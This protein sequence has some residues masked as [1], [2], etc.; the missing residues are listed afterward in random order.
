MKNLTKGFLFAVL[1]T[2]AAISSLNAQTL[3]LQTT[4]EY[5][6]S[7]TALNN[8]VALTQT[9]QNVTAVQSMTY[10]FVARQTP[11]N[12]TEV[13]AYFT[14]WDPVT[15]R[16]TSVTPLWTP[17]GTQTIPASTNPSWQ[18]FTDRNG[19]DYL[20]Y[21]YT[22]TPAMAALNPNQTYAIILRAVSNSGLTATTRIG[23][24]Q[25]F[26]TN[27]SDVFTFGSAL[28]L[29]STVDFNTFTST[30]SN[31]LSGGSDWGFQQI[32][33]TPV[34]EPQTAAAILAVLFIAGLAAR[35]LYLKRQQAALVPVH[36]TAA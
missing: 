23:L 11:T 33:I 24:Q 28:S 18:T 27:P 14:A 1:S 19:D 7:T 35:R 30:S 15:R 36:V 26:D 13:E 6:G 3:T 32:V 22:L 25:I 16:A 8:N 29:S 17:V 9:F 20:G 2:A 21:D 34:P 4:Q 12:E 31:L 10:R 5:D